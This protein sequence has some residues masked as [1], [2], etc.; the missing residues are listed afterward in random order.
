[1]APSMVCRSMKTSIGACKAIRYWIRLPSKFGIRWDDDIWM[2][3]DVVD[4]VG[5]VVSTKIRPLGS[6]SQ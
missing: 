2:H 4:T 3:K 1:M 5:T 6:F